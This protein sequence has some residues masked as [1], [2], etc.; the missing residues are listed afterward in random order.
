VVP[1][2]AT[3][4][5]AAWG[6]DVVIVLPAGNYV[7]T[8]RR[9]STGYTCVLLRVSQFLNMSISKLI[10]PTLSI[11]DGGVTVFWGVADAI[12]AAQVILTYLLASALLTTYE[13]RSLLEEA[14]VTRNRDGFWRRLPRFR[15]N[16]ACKDVGKI[17][18]I[19][20]NVQ[21]HYC[22]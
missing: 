15:K 17:G 21:F 6:S 3:N 7:W 12:N 18:L 16:T 13:R 14:T 4:L 1:E 9:T 8:I 20:I 22:E 5:Q 11:Q 10:F 19:E 2:R